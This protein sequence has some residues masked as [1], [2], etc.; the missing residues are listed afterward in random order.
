MYDFVAGDNFKCS[1][2]SES[3]RRFLDNTSAILQKSRLSWKVNMITQTRIDTARLATLTILWNIY[4][5][6]G[7]FSAPE[8]L[9]IAFEEALRKASMDNWY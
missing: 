3:I 4:K 5:H 7:L 2:P 6:F 9:N 1:Y 8:E